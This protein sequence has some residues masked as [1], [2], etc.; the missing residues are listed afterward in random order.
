MEITLNELLDNGKALVIKNKNYFE[1]RA[2]VEPFLDRMS[3]YTNNFSCQVKLPDTMTKQD[4][5]LDQGFTRVWVQAIL[6]DEYAY[7]NH[8][9]SVSL[10]YAL[11]TRKP[12][13]KMFKSTI[14][15]ACLN[16]CT[17]N[18]EH[19][20]VSIL[21]PE[22][23]MNFRFITDV[24]EMADKTQMMLKK[25]AETYLHKKY[26]LETLG[27]WVDRCIKTSYDNGYNKVKL[28][29]SLPIEVYKNLFINEDSDYYCNGYDPTYFDV[30]NSWTYLISNDKGKDIVNKF[31]KIWLISQ[32]LGIE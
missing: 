9:Q 21:E 19:L 2:Y 16:M 29:E 13:V 11:D 25:Y 3:K 32:I 24:M 28:A 10:L 27:T 6:P 22:T 20:Q 1:T 17:F 18:P 15:M 5:I 4:N 7:E 31:E 23:A 14:N 30:Y 8:Q 26:I 12:I